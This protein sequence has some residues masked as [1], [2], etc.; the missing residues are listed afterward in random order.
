MISKQFDRKPLSRLDPEVQAV[1]R[2]LTSRRGRV[3]LSGDETVNSE[4]K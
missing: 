1:Q 3:R 2:L 4:Q